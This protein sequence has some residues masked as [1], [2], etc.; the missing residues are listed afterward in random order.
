MTL[1]Q[2]EWRNSDKGKEN[3][4]RSKS[5]LVA[6]MVLNNYDVNVYHTRG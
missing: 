2:T 6:H 5:K 1:L 4:T 3:R